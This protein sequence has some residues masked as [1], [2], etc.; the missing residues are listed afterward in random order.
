MRDA[1]GSALFP[2]RRL[3]LSLCLIAAAGLLLAAPRGRGS[4]PAAARVTRAR[5]L[6]GTVLEI[7]AVGP[8]RDR[9]EAAI[10]EAFEEV[11][12]TEAR[13]SNWRPG[14][15]L[16]RAN[17]AA[18]SEPLRLTP[19]TFFSLERAIAL[20]RETEGAFDPTVGG[21]TEALGLT[22]RAP[23]PAGAELAR[24]SIGWRGALLDPAS[25]T[26]RLS[27]SAA[28]IDS[29]AF[30]KGEALDR[31]IARL[32]RRGAEA[33]RLNFGGQISLLGAETRAGRQ[34]GWDRVAV[35][36]PESSRSETCRFRMRDGSVSTSGV[37]EK[38]G[39]LIDPRTGGAA[40]FRGSVTV[41][42]G[43]GLRADALSTALFVLGPREGLDFANRRGIAALFLV[44]SKAGWQLLATEGFPACVPV[45]S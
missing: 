27:S 23:D 9:L 17:R 14:S 13:L 12:R 3:R 38:P 28:A 21:L 7:D 4:S 32:S 36:A 42:A 40:T 11:A 29:G 44:P 15:E 18:S 37:S 43:T 41:L 16:S 10:A 30:G 5:Y 6:M 20:S 24:G 34:A 33:A 19:E 8:G 1:S 2:F 35:A 39:H 26:L 22:G 45:N 31:A 25:R